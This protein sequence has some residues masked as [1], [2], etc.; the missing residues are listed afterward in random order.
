MDRRSCL[1]LATGEKRRADVVIGNAIQ[2]KFKL[3]HYLSYRK[4][5]RGTLIAR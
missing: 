5:I 2:R 1:A 4:N 3:R